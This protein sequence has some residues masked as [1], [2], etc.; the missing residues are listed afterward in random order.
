MPDNPWLLL[1]FATGL[2]LGAMLVWLGVRSGKIGA[3]T[4]S[5]E[6]FKALAADAVRGNN[7]SFLALAGEHLGRREQ[8]IDALVQ[9]LRESLQR[10]EKQIKEME[11]SRQRG[12]GG[13]SQELRL[14]ADSHQR[15]QKE[16]GNLVTALRQ[17][18]VRGRWGE[19]TLRRVAELAGMVEHCDFQEQVSVL[20]EEGRVRPDLVVFLPNQRQVVVDSKV[21]LEAYLRFTLAG[22]DEARG[23]A[24]DE[25]V[26]Q[27]RAHMSQLSSRAYWSNFPEAPEFVV[28]FIP[29]ESFLAAAAQQDQSLIENGLEKNVVIATPTTLVALLKAVAYGWRQERLAQNARII[30]DQARELYQRTNVLVEHLSR[31][32]RGLETAVEAWNKAVGSLEARWLP[33]AR[34]VNE[35]LGSNE[36]ELPDLAPVDQIPRAITAPEAGDGR[37]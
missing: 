37:D 16:T 6:T 8:A 10:Y 20:T 15:L 19:L 5:A 4:A 35:L 3:T 21:P 17:P 26:R 29:G 22:S 36:K 18:Q 12:E 25:H 1:A 33:Q 32:Q 11:E 9:P 24:L 2:A 31:V 34:R 13:L 28:M 30:G 23:I 7:E 27:M 14:L